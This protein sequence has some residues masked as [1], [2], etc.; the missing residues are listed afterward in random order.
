MIDARIAVAV[1]AP[2]SHDLHA[3]LSRLA[4]RCQVAALSDGGHFDAVVRTPQIPSA[5]GERTLL[6]VEAADAPPP[7]ANHAVALLAP[8]PVAR[9]LRG[10]AGRPVVALGPPAVHVT[11]RPVLPFTRARIRRARHLQG[12]AVARYL[13]GAWTWDGRHLDDEASSTAAA[14]ASVVVTDDD[15]AAVLAAAWSAPVVVP[16]DVAS[17]T[18]LPSAGDDLEAAADA[19]LA[20]DARAARL[21]RTCRRTF[22]L[23]HDPD[24]A[25]AQLTD[26]LVLR[27]AR[28][29]DGGYAA[30]LDRL[31]TPPDARIRDRAHAASDAL[32]SRR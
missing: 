20:D 14:L 27:P 13:D 3:A 23:D 32:R 11:A 4:E 9:R 31:G 19:V 16:A 26:L 1:R 12:P 5:Y 24:S 6:W 10:T 22:E 18:G 30:V 8:P 29:W 17:R 28:P 2:A 7:A 15:D 21:A 25:L